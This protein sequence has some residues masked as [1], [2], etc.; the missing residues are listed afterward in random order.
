MTP[1]E[2]VIVE[3]QHRIEKKK[4]SRIKVTLSDTEDRLSVAVK[5]LRTIIRSPTADPQSKGVAL[6]AL[7]KIGT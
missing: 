3:A 5:A 6:G 1:Q 2:K 7:K 4:L